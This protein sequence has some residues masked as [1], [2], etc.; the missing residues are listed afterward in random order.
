MKPRSASCCIPMTLSPPEKPP[1]G[2]KALGT[3]LS[4]DI[5]ALTAAGFRPP[6]RFTAKGRD[7]R[8]DIYGLVVR[9]AQVGELLHPHDLVAAG[10]AAERPEGLG[11]ETVVRPVTALTAAGFR[12]PERFTAK[13]RDGR[14][15]I[16]GLVVRPRDYRFGQ[17]G[18]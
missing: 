14:T 13:G 1:N 10:K 17:V 9:P 15:D 12:P 8:T 2:Q 6:E 11:H 3:K 7:G 16:Y 18:A 4:C 5:T